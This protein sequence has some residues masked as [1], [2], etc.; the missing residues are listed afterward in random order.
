MRWSKKCNFF[1]IERLELFNYLSPDKIVISTEKSQISYSNFYNACIFLGRK[2]KNSKKVIIL[3]DEKD[4]AVLGIFSC[5]MFGITYIPVSHDIPLKRI[6]YIIKKTNPDTLLVTK[7]LSKY[8]KLPINKK[9]IIDEKYYKIKIKF[10]KYVK[11]FPL[12][13]IAYIIFT[14]GSTGEPKGVKISREALN[15]FTKYLCR[16]F[17]DNQCKNFSLF[18]PLGFDLSVAEIFGAICTGSKLIPV[19]NEYF[20]SFPSEFIYKKKITHVIL[21]PSCISIIQQLGTNVNKKFLKNV[22]HFVFCGEV[23]KKIHIEYLFKCKKNLRVTN[24]Y[25]PT[26]AT[27]FCT[28]ID[29]YKNNYNQF[30][31]KDVCIGNEISGMKIKIVKD[32]NYKNNF[33]QVLISGPQVSSGYFLNKKLNQEKFRNYYNTFVSGD[34]V[35]KIDNNLYF[36]QRNDNQIKRWG[37]RIELD[38]ISRVI[39]KYLKEST[40]CETIFYNGDLYSFI[41]N[42]NNIKI[43]NNKILQE[44]KKNIPKY[45]LPK[46][47]IGMKYLPLNSNGKID[48]KKLIEYIND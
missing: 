9:V 34:I 41:L 1:P 23:L 26:E 35:E 13:N 6:L 39:E 45:M 47:I 20:K 37:N 28:A 18:A 25:G 33:G 12:Q 4:K 27:V 29:L 5:L 44:I 22:K 10:K 19:E 21:V 16:L 43:N 32:R 46:K 31:K 38:E 3:D 42:V 30:S 2:I 24:T 8:F 11:N 48:K 36:L 14:S 15:N 17:S 40:Q 7:K